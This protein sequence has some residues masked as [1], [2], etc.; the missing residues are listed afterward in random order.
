MPVLNEADNLSARLAELAPLQRRGV[1]L[2]LVDGGSSD[3]TVA[4]ARSAAVEVIQSSPGRAR[5]MMTGVAA[6]KGAI[7]LFLHADTVLPQDA[8]V[9]VTAALDEGGREWGRFDVRIEGRHWMLPVIATMMNL[10]SR[11]TGIAT[12]DQAIFVTRRAFDAVGG[13][14]DLAL[15][16]D[17][18][19]SA[20]LRRRS[21]PVCLTAR[22]VTS[23]RRWERHGLWR[24]IWLMWRLR[25]QFWR[26]VPASVLARQYR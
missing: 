15:M 23:G 9:L 4:I 22:A 16:E 10:R 2:I 7:L 26:G 11:W 24:T 21:R 14:P 12:G 17:I 25:C 20:R 18:V 1:Q 19:L 5:Q 13:Y 3:D 6:S 8:D